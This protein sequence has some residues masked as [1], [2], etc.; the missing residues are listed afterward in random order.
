MSTI[1]GILLF[2]LSKKVTTPLN[3]LAK[4]ADEIA[5]GNYGKKVKVKSSDYEI[6]ALSKS[7]N[8]MSSAIE[9]KIEQT[10]LFTIKWRV[11]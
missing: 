10:E 8:S 4:V 6:S 11:V 9:Q 2:A 5:L 3:K 7:V 1:S